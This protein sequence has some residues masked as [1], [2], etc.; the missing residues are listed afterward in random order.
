HSL[1]EGKAILEA[2][3]KHKRIVQ[4]GTQQRSMPQFVAGRE[5]IK[6]GRL[7]TVHRVRLSW[8][9]NTDR[10][11]KNPLGI[12]PA[13]VDWKAFLGSAP[14]GTST[15]SPTASG[16]IWKTG[17]TR[18]ATRNS[19]A[20]RSTPAWGPRPRRTWRTRRC[21]AGR[22]RSGRGEPRRSAGRPARRRGLAGARAA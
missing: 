5:L 10:I 20:A 13:K 3:G 18:S 6:Q 14:A 22:W 21:A 4:V 2:L 11:R 12:D 1:E 9:R 19:R 8:N 17:S 7:G 16:C 15:T